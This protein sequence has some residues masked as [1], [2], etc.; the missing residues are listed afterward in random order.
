MAKRTALDLEGLGGVVADAL[1]DRQIIRHP[2]DLFE[3]EAAGRLL[4]ILSVLNLGTHEEPRIFGAKNAAKLAS[5]VRKARTLPLAR[6]LHALAIP[7]VGETIACQLAG[8]HNSIEDAAESALLKDVLA[9]EHLRSSRE[10]LNP[11]AM[12]NRDKP[13][14]EKAR[15][16]ALLNAADAEAAAVERSLI[17]RGFAEESTRKDGS[18]SVVALVG[19]VVAKS[20]LDYFASAAGAETLSRLKQL[21]IRPVAD[22]AP[23]GS[24]RLAGK[25]FVLTGALSGMSRQEATDRIR[26]LGGAVASSVSKGTDFVVAGAE[27]GAKL[28]AAIRLNIPVLTEQGFADMLGAPPCASVQESQPAI[29]PSPSGT[30]EV[31]QVSIQR[32]L[33]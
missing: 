10:N 22:A 30:R 12:V 20:V 25:T 11:R 23:A 19:P 31:G 15:L 13:D 4:D 21:G 33:F 2:L 1:V 18:R 28:E 5:A 29:Q 26:A 24:S 17:E 14:E 6:W 3:L 32:E 27:A 8:T 9:L 7:D 16:L